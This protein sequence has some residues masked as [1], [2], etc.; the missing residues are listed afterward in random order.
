MALSALLA[1]GAVAA[2]AVAGLRTHPGGSGGGLAA[3]PNL[4]PGT[5]LDRQAPGFALI[6]QFGHRVSLGSYR[7][8]VVLLA[9][10]DSRCTTICPLTTSAMLDAQRLLGRAGRHVQLLGVNANPAATAISEVRAYSQAH[11]MIKRWR[12]L[13]GSR[14]ELRRVWRAY[15]IEA[16]VLRGQIDHTPAMF[17][18]DPGG[19]ERK[20][21][22]TQMNY[23]TVQQLGEILAHEASTLLPGRPK[24]QSRPSYTPQ[25]LLTPSMNV[26]LP[27]DGGGSIRLGPSTGPR[28]TLFFATWVSQTSKLAGALQALNRYQAATASLH[29]P[30]LTAIDE[31]TVE[32]SPAALPRFLH[33]LPD[34]LAYPVAVDRTGQVADGYE[35]QDEPWFVLTSASGQLLWYDD[36]TNAGWPSTNA[37]ISDVRAAL[38]HT[39]PASGG[40]G[41]LN[42]SPAPLA[43]L[44]AQAGQLL[45]TTG[46]L[47]RIRSLRGYPVVLNAW[48]SWCGPCRAEFKLFASAS[49]RYGRQVAFLGADTDDSPG[50]ARAF[51]E[52]HPV[53]YPSYQTTTAGLAPLAAVAGLPT[54][55]FI[56]PS[57]KVVY[58]HTGQYDT[59][60]TLDHDISTYALK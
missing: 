60:G 24:V 21:Y 35:V 34:A 16:N 3:N 8:R 58:V 40:G 41:E 18:I 48:A 27:G 13:T 36:P 19:V 12:F 9:F 39:R 11:G 7:G 50:D 51:L 15:G 30:P 32:P 45:G 20:V 4:D 2:L 10:I 14:A 38:A 17:A 49:R 56:G 47:Q 53:S 25:P 31:A 52:Q 26:A 44:H 6:D 55:I 1:L 5:R 42:G 59:Q 29:L 43:S 33:A 23:T 46:L 22:L 37:L 28:L 57:S 54:T